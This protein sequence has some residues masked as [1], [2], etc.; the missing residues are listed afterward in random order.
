MRK[1]VAWGI[2]TFT[3][4]VTC[5]VAGH[6][7]SDGAAVPLVGILALFGAIAGTVA[8]AEG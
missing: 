7:L 5:G 6:F 1:G 3:I 8:V 2:V 4:G